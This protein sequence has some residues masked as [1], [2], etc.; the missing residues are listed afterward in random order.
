MALKRLLH[1]L[2]H[3]ALVVAMG[4]H[5]DCEGSAASATAVLKLHRETHAQ[6]VVN[7]PHVGL[8]FL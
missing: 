6:L 4:N 1:L 5:L 8:L 3:S 7:A 2:H